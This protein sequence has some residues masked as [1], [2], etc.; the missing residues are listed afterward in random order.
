M[1][2][3]KVVAILRNDFNCDWI[4]MARLIKK[5]NTSGWSGDI[6]TIESL[7]YSNER[8]HMQVENGQCWVKADHEGAHQNDREARVMHCK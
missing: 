8:M 4:P 1:L 2:E 5:L 3:R 7:I 6:D